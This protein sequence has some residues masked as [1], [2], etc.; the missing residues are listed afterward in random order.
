MKKR[1]FQFLA[2]T[3]FQL[4]VHFSPEILCFFFASLHAMHTC[5]FCGT[6]EPV[7]CKHLSHAFVWEIV[8]RQKEA[9][10]SEPIVD[11]LCSYITAEMHK[12]TTSNAIVGKEAQVVPGLLSEK[13]ADDSDI[14]AVTAKILRPILHVNAKISRHF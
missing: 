13:D 9:G 3:V 10:M 4:F 8:Q 14:D 1:N 11:F 12:P 2:T 5:I 6:R 7:H